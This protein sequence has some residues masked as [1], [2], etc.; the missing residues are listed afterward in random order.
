[1]Y[2]TY[3][4]GGAAHNADFANDADAQLRVAGGV[5]IV[6]DL[7]VG[8]DFYIGKVGTND[9]VEFSVLGESGFTTIGRAGQGNATD[10]AIIVH[11]NATFNREVN[12]TGALTTIGD[13]NTDVLTVN[14][15]SQFTDDVTV[16][17]SLTV[18]TNALIEGNL[19]V[20]GTTTT[21]NSTVVTIDDTVFT[22][23][24]DTAPGQS[25]AKDRGIEFR[26]YDN[27]AKIG[28]FGWDTSASRYALYHAATNNSEAFSGTRSGLDAGSLALFDTTNATNSGTGTLTVGGGAGIGLSLFVGENLDVSGNAVVDGNVDLSLIHI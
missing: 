28:F 14:A 10:G 15:V 2:R 21:V 26:Y 5:G 3:L 13:A 18:N 16:D 8:D 19:T 17:G 6:Q 1:M 11:G 25:D 23:G 9:N 4:G 24:G 7:H 12:I 20:N 27:S 22:L